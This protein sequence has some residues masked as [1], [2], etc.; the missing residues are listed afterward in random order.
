MAIDVGSPVPRE[1]RRRST[2]GTA[3]MRWPPDPV[4]GGRPRPPRSRRSAKIT[5]A[6]IAANAAG[7]RRSCGRTVPSDQ[8]SRSRRGDDRPPRGARGGRDRTVEWMIASTTARKKH[9]GAD[10]GAESHDDDVGGPVDREV[11]IRAPRR[12]GPFNNS[13]HDALQSAGPRHRTAWRAEPLGNIQ[14]DAEETRKDHLTPK[15]NHQ[16]QS[17]LTAWASAERRDR[18]EALVRRSSGTD[19]LRG[20]AAGAGRHDAADERRASPSDASIGHDEEHREGIH[21]GASPLRCAARAHQRIT[22]PLTI[23]GPATRAKRR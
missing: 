13:L 5:A 8:R 4:P 12:R 2:R 1:S 16:D 21:R 19:P 7:R 15:V 11:E 23:P 17:Q 18:I 9:F 10:R 14:G 3:G 6:R 22:P 20:A